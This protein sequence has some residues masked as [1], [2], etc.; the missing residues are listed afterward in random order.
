MKK[1][2]LLCLV[3]VLV[4]CLATALVACDNSNNPPP[5]DKT[6]TSISADVSHDKFS[7]GQFNYALGETIEIGESNFT[8][9]AYYSDGSEE[10]VDDFS[11]T[12]DIPSGDVPAGIYTV[13][14]SYSTAS[15][16]YFTVEVTE[17]TLSLDAPSFTNPEYTGSEIDITSVA[18]DGGKTIGDFITDNN[19]VI[20]EDGDD[21]QQT[22][23]GSYS[24][25]LRSSNVNLQG[26][27]T[28]KWKVERK[29]LALADFLVVTNAIKGEEA[30]VYE[31]TYGDGACSLSSVNDFIATVFCFDSDP[32]DTEYRAGYYSYTCSTG[33]NYRFDTNSKEYR[34]QDE[35]SA[36]F[37]LVIRQKDISSFSLADYDAADIRVPYKDKQYNSSD[38]TEA[39]FNLSK[40]L[41]LGIAEMSQGDD[42]DNKNASTDTVKG[43]F[44][45]RGIDNYTGTLLVP[46]TILPLDVSDGNVQFRS[47]AVYNG[48]AQSLTWVVYVRESSYALTLVEDTD[49]T[50]TYSNNVNAGEASF[51]I[52]GKGN[53]T[54][55]KS[56]KFTIEKQIVQVTEEWETTHPYEF[57]YDGTVHPFNKLKEE[58]KITDLVN[59]V[60]KL[61]KYREYQSGLEGGNF[62]LINAG[63]YQCVAELAMKDP[64]NYA[65]YKNQQEIT[66]RTIKDDKDITIYPV[67]AIMTY[68]GQSEFEYTGDP[69]CL[70]ES[71]ITV[72]TLDGVQKTLEKDT[73]YTLTYRGD[74]V[75]ANEISSRHLVVAFPSRNYYFEQG[76][77]YTYEKIILFKIKQ[78]ILEDSDVEITL[79]QIYNIVWGR[80][81]LA[82]N[83][84]GSVKYNGKELPI[85]FETEKSGSG[86]NW[87]LK[88]TCDNENYRCY[89][90]DRQIIDVNGLVTEEFEELY[91][92]YNRYF[93]EVKR[94]GVA[95]SDDE[96]VAMR[97]RDAFEIGDKLEFTCRE[98]FEI[99][100]SFPYTP[101]VE[102][103]ERARTLTYEIGSEKD[104]NGNYGFAKTVIFSLYKEGDEN[105]MDTKTFYFEYK[106]PKVFGT[107]DVNGE[108]L[109]PTDWKPLKGSLSVSAGDSIVISCSADF[110]E[111]SVIVKMGNEAS[112]K[113]TSYNSTVPNDLE[114]GDQVVVEVY[115]LNN[116]TP[117]MVF[118]FDVVAAE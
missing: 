24:L 32:R 28:I 68:T 46:F 94:N 10:R 89:F 112:D 71:L 60:Y 76:E 107:F 4:L 93:S 84:G 57:T 37:I 79:P 118:T 88:I 55:T 102:A 65:F 99:S 49:Y 105:A 64:A 83:H 69:I 53:Y 109:I 25:V 40:L 45:I 47:D 11:V 62:E 19:L 36:S 8:V 92:V 27:L 85:T 2:L 39:P 16:L 58:S 81:E 101:G 111:Y 63:R 80:L 96:L 116:E 75:N 23:A 77:H 6:L 9:T 33:G 21:K 7:N 82:S 18:I 35:E 106:Y 44:Q 50:I 61:D 3:A 73:D 20:T 117:F 14:V 72:K 97:L 70:D 110:R 17:E 86:L 38:F 30:N 5:E 66:E 26:T 90:L 104:A 103:S 52:T 113:V 74:H 67:H 31:S 41:A 43:Q 78:K 29:T 100:M 1:K 15:S 13:T 34:A 91:S 54:G 87:W 56:D 114:P 22:N 98:G 51:T 42:I 108:S 95:V 48:E 115:R 59:V 12:S